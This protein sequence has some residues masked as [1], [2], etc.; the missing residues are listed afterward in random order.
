VTRSNVTFATNLKSHDSE[1]RA[2]TDTRRFTTQAAT[3]GLGYNLKTAK[4]LSTVEPSRAA[5]KYEN[6]TLTPKYDFR[7]IRTVTG[8]FTKV[9]VTVDS[10]PAR[11]CG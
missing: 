11:G 2:M 9:P 10:E 4:S 8:Q 7:V 5:M 6:H 3:V 1:W